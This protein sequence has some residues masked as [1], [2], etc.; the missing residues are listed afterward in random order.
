[1]CSACDDIEDVTHFLLFCQIYTHIRIDLPTGRNVSDLDKQVL[2][3]LLLFGNEKKY[4]FNT[5]KRILL[6]T[7]TYIKNSHR[8]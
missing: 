3:K 1:M 4:S 6:S 2:V 7:I 8:F 5:N